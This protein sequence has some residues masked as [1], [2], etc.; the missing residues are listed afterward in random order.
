MQISIS[1]PMVREAVFL[2]YKGTCFYSG[3][4]IKRDEM[5]I[6]HLHPVSKGGNDSFHNYVLTFQDFNLGKSNKTDSNLI[7]R[8][9]YAIETVY[10]PRAIKIYEKLKKIQKSK[11]SR[12]PSNL[13]HIKRLDLFWADDGAIEVLTSSSLVTEKNNY[14]ILKSLDRFLEIARRDDSD[15]C[16]DVWMTSEF[17]K[18]LR[19]IWYQVAGKYFRIVRKTKYYDSK[20]P[21][22]WAWVYFSQE[23]LDFLE[24]RKEESQYLESIGEIE[25]ETEH[26]KLLNKFCKKYPPP[27]KYKDQIL[28]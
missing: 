8:L 21:D 10:A 25:D 14:E 18:Q 27:E 12:K 24:W 22:K 28:N 19:S 11:S 16:F 5:V 1:N 17:G 20:S 26:K 2:A 4:P 23:S 3:R 15:F 13:K 6:D 7:P 9:Q